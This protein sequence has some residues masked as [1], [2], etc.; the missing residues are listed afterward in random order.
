MKNLRISTLLL[1]IAAL[2]LASCANNKKKQNAELEVKKSEI[3]EIVSDYVYPLP[4]SVELMEML[5]EINAAYIIG[6]S[7]LS[8]DVDKYE[9]KSKQAL[10]LGVYL[11]DLSYASIYRRKQTAQDYLGSC[12]KLIRELRVD[13]S[14]EDGFADNVSNNIDKKETLVSLLTTATQNLYSD[15]HRKGH[16][17]LAYLMAAGAWTETM[18]LTLEVSNNTPLNAKIVNTIIFQHQS[19][20]EIIKLLQEVNTDGKTNVLIAALEGIKN[21]FNQEDPSAL[22]VE[23]FKKLHAQTK[24]LREHLVE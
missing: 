23:Q 9:T 11:S 14:F 6:I 4:T 19:L 17:D 24:A 7:N 1:I 22:T 12:E 21:T 3:A 13:G 15:L 20:L 8:T 5:N 16:K 2:S 10:N 18:Y